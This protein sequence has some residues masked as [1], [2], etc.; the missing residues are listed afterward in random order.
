M[1]AYFRVEARPDKGFGH[2]VRCLS[3]AKELK[4][5][6]GFKDCI[7]FLDDYLQA[8]DFVREK[9]LSIITIPKNCDEQEF[10]LGF[11]Y[12]KKSVIIIDNLY[13][14]SAN[15][16][17][18]LNGKL[19][20]I[21]I[22]S[23]ADGRFNG[24]L[25]IYPAAHLPE[26]FLEDKNWKNTT[27]KLLA[28]FN[29]CFLNSDILKS[30]PVKKINKNV[31]TVIFVAGGSDPSNSLL[32][33]YKWVNSFDFHNISFKFLYG[34]NSSYIN[35]LNEIGKKDNIV[36]IPF[37]AHE[38]KN[39]DI[40]IC[41]FGVTLY[42]LIYLNIPTISYGH[43]EKHA[44][45]SRRFENKYHCI[46]NIGTIDSLSKNLFYNTLKSSINNFTL[47]NEIFEKTKNL[48]N[49]RGIKRVCK[50]I[51]KLTI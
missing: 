13:N 22:H 1:I 36:F 9:N 16:I 19:K 25:A 2:L 49:G 14:Y 48:I 3:L 50:E 44:E 47:R 31:K 24:S 32:L 4:L 8:I 37:D 21:L 34:K 42:E 29:Y 45:A 28:G 10:L 46:K 20:T 17:K 5:N 12:S 38:L 15:T 6:Y 40:A 35:S 26:S 18:S 33:F 39:A 51:K 30:G 41:A 23:Y 11:D 27:V 43:T 7:F